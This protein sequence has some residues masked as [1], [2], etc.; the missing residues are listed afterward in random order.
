MKLLSHR[1]IIP[2]L[3]IAASPTVFAQEPADTADVNHKLE[4]VVV[5]AQSRGIRGSVATNTSLIS[6]RELT[7]A[8]CCN[9]GESFTTNPSVDVSYSDAAT[10]ARQI[11]L[12]GLSGAYVQMLTENVPAARGASAPYYL[13]YIAGPWMQSIQVSKGASSVKNGYESVTGQINIEMLKPQL[14][15]S[16]SLNAYVDHMGKAEL[17]ALGNIHIG[18]KWSTGLLT[19]FENSFATHDA[20][21]DTFVDTPRLRQGALMNRWAYLGR[22]YVFQAAVKGL[23]EDRRSGQIG[24]AAHHVADPYVIDIDTKRIEAFTKNAYIYDRENEG[25]IALILSGN[26]HDMDASYGSKFYDITQRELYASLMFE[27]KWSGGLHALSTGLSFNHDDFDRHY[28]LEPTVSDAD[29]SRQGENVYGVYGQYTLNLNGRLVAMAGVR[30][31]Y[32]SVYG[33]LVTPRLHVRWNVS[34][35]VSLNASAGRGRRSPHPLEEYNY[36]LASSRKIHLPET[37]SLKMETADN[38]G[39][40]VKWSFDLGERSVSLGAE[41]YYTTFD[42]CLLADLNRDPHAVFIYS[43]SRDAWSHAAQFEA[44]VDI[45]ED[46]SLTAAYRYIDV[47][48]DYGQGA[49]Q[50]P[51]TSR[52][53]GL[54]SIDY[55]P[56]MGLWQFDVTYSITG[57][58]KMPA[59]YR[60]PD[61]SESWSSSYKAFGTLNAQVT[62]NF[63]NWSVYLGGEN[64]TG[65]KQKNPIIDA[66]NPRGNDFDATMIYGPLHGAVVYVGFRYNITKYL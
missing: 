7:R 40:G 52:S 56:M 42:N 62:R 29:Y 57:G 3:I 46:M 47:K 61:G 2:S 39:A 43:S 37:R 32:N 66:H 8:A 33:S 27:R 6:A 60:L 48:V 38:M 12:L 25:N 9:L 54:F 16:L 41:Y 53:K 34:D 19:H 20:N 36:L 15:P 59:N 11:K 49:V 22:N 28:R 14:D 30:Y 1:Y 24:H 63:R 21:D 4:E 35:N 17:N 55:R 50:K 5:S 26:I 23:L 31:D 18:E 45:I 64:L 51:L 13:G 58:G 10:G 44:T 65:Y